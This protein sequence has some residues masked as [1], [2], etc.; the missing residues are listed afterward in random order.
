MPQTVVVETRLREVNGR[1]YV[2]EADLKDSDGVVLAQ[3]EALWI[4]VMA[5]L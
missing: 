3:G 2:V 4:A 1:K 5:S